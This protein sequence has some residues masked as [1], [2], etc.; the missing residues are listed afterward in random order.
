MIWTER[1]QVKKGSKY[2]ELQMRGKGTERERCQESRDMDR[3]VNTKVRKTV[4]ERERK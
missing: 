3:K 4:R 1:R 2:V